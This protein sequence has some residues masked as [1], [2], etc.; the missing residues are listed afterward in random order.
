MRSDYIL[1]GVAILCFIAA[2][3]TATITTELYVYAIAVLGIVFI[4]LGYMARPKELVSS[5]ATPTLQPAPP[6]PKPS[7]KPSSNPKTEAKEETATKTKKTTTKKRTRKKRSRS[8]RK[9]DT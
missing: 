1:Y 4:G 7:S 2:A 6:P 9:K 5:T 3:Y 8:K